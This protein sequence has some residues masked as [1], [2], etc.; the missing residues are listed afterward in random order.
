M[1]SSL[2]AFILE[3]KEISR[4]PAEGLWGFLV[5]FESVD[6]LIEGA[7]KVRDAGYTNWDAHSPFPVHGLDPAMGIRPTKLPFFVFGGGLTGGGL[8][9]L[10]QWWMN[11]VNYPFISSGKPFFSLPANI[12]VMFELTVLFAAFGAFIGMLIFNRLPE[13]YH[14]LFNSERFRRVTTD[15]FFI[16]IEA[17]DPRFDRKETW[18]FMKTLGGSHLEEVQG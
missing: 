2:K 9:L 15:R 18:K 11:A 1:F 6:A 13:H 4:G 7:R 16:S 5:E 12:P 17:K 14:P 3:M 8:G 10:M